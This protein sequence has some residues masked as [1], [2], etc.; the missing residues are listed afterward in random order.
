MNQRFRDNFNDNIKTGSN[1][2]DLKRCVS[3]LDEFTILVEKL[4][5]ALERFLYTDQNGNELFEAAKK[6]KAFL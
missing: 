2:N 6:V 3:Q 1:I 4:E 5:N